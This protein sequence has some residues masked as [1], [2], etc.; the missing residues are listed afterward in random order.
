MQLTRTLSALAVGSALLVAAPAEAAPKAKLKLTKVSNAPKTVSAGGKFNLKAT[1][2]NKGRKAGKG[3]VTMV[4]T[5][6]RDVG[7]WRQNLAWSRW[8]VP[9]DLWQELTTAGLLAFPPPA[10]LV[11]AR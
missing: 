2:T 6:A 3:T 1:V 7:Q 5:G 4:L 11:E 9:T 10:A 8:P